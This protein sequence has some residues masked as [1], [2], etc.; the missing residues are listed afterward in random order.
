MKKEI[1]NSEILALLH[2]HQECNSWLSEI[3]MWQHRLQFMQ[4]LI[5][6]FST[7]LED[8][9]WRLKLRTYHNELNGS[10]GNRINWLAEKLQ[11]HQI[12]IQSF[13]KEPVVL[14]L[15]EVNIQHDTF[16]KEMGLLRVEYAS[17]RETFFQLMKPSLKAVKSRQRM[18]RVA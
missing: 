18:E 16:Q 2:K 8:P 4:D 11:L 9:D 5:L 1:E 13:F 3:E 17:I 7:S 6:R 12:G 10:F 14:S 15:S